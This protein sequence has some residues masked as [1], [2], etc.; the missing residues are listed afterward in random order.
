MPGEFKISQVIR[1]YFKYRDPKDGRLV[2]KEDEKA[3]Y[4]LLDK[5]MEEFRSMGDVYLSESMK[6]WKIMETP[7][8]SAGVS[9]YTGWLELT[10][11]MGEFPKEELGRIL[12]AYS[13]KKKYYRLKSGQFLMLDKGGMFTLTKLAGELGISKKRSAKRHDPPACV[14]S[15]VSGS[16]FKR[17][18]GHYLLQRPAV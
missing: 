18:S 2:L 17:R 5:G 8:V 4:H 16:Y 3:L 10:V 6:N 13:Q 12:A 14:Q 1:K 9:A 11:D 7:T 15:L